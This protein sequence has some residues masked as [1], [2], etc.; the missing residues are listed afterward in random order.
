[1]ALDLN[2]TRFMSW[3]GMTVKLQQ[4][5]WPYIVVAILFTFE[6]GVY[7]F[8]IRSQSFRYIYTNLCFFW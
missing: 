1:M 3:L 7:V 8:M 4:M 2:G 6:A 5:D